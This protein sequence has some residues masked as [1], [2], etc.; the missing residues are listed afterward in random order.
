[1]KGRIPFSPRG[2]QKEEERISKKFHGCE[3]NF[4]TFLGKV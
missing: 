3:R 1:M 4:I 2:E